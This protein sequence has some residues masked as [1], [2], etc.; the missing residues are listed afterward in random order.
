MI[1]LFAVK[2]FLT[3]KM[4]FTVKM[5]NT[6][7]MFYRFQTVLYGKEAV[8]LRSDKPQNRVVL[9]SCSRRYTGR[10]FYPTRELMVI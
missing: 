10:S 1:N 7:K 2:N 9:Q 8:L 6:V 5:S 3:V 4:Y